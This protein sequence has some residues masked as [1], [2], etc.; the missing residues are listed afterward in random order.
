[1]TSWVCKPLPNDDYWSSLQERLQ[2]SPIIATLLAQRGISDG[3]SKRFFR[4]QLEHLRPISD[5]GYG[6]GGGTSI[7]RNKRASAHHGIR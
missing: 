1:M 6:Q 5:A 3:Q 7:N 4:P 2:V